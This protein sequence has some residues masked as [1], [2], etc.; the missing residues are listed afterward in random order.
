MYICMC[1]CMYVCKYVC[2]C[3]YIYTHTINHIYICIY[4]HIRVDMNKRSITK[5]VCYR[6]EHQGGPTI[7]HN[8]KLNIFCGWDSLR[9][10]PLRQ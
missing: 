9:G 2:M 10:A 7:D 8:T 6:L 1:I 4:T 5:R 3:V